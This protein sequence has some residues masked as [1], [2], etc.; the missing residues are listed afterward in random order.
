MTTQLQQ[1]EKQFEQSV[2]DYSKLMGWMS[3]H[4]LDS[5]G[6]EPGFPD[7]VFVRVPRIVIAEF[8]AE[9]GRLS[10]AQKIWLRELGAVADVI[11][12]L[13]ELPELPGSNG[14]RIGLEVR[15]WY[16]G[17]WDEIQAV[18]R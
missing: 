9:K 4:N 6:S 15:V 14:Q 8:K 5:R 18:L 10:V 7:R 3:Y 11:Q 16:P 12:Q 17:D 13:L 2:A 1:S